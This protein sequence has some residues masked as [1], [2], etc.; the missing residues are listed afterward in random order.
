MATQRFFRQVNMF[1]SVQ[2]NGIQQDLE[3]DD[4]GQI[5]IPAGVTPNEFQLTIFVEKSRER[6]C[7]ITTKNVGETA[8]TYHRRHLSALKTADEFCYWEAPIEVARAGQNVWT[9]WHQAKP[10]RVDCFVIGPNGQFGLF[11]IGVITHD[12][13][14]TWLSHGEWRWQ[15]T[16][17]KQG[18]QYVAKP[19]AIHWGKF[20]T[21]KKIFD[22]QSFPRLV[23]E[24]QLQEWSG[25]PEELD[26]P[27]PTPK[28]GQ[29]V[30][31]WFVPF[32]GQ[33]GQGVAVLPESQRRKRKPQD[34]SQ[35]DEGVRVWI[36][37][38]DILQD[39]DAD[40]VKRLRRGDVIT[41]SGTD[42]FGKQE[43]RMP[44]ALNIQRK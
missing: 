20:E 29:A 19:N 2:V 4:D 36:H 24:T 42:S 28:E 10:N 6:T 38:A 22:H 31:E 26:P 12:D 8:G 7:L 13:G 30:V 32:G 15:G 33:T 5:E 40:G 44:K 16:L 9:K 43:G 17:Y 1:A 41:F 3:I 14:Q 35:N 27:L 34:P 37:G 23:R 21:W 39:L 25:T 11:Q 18:D